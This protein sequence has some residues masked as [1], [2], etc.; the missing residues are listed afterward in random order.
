MCYSREHAEQVKARLAVM[1]LERA[2]MPTPIDEA[3]GHLRG[4]RFY[5]E[6]AWMSCSLVIV[7][8]PAMPF[9]FAS[10]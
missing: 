3:D 4:G 8:R 1:A 5:F 2:W 10:A 6:R 7:E 9:F